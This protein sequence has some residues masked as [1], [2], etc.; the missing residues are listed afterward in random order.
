[1]TLPGVDRP[2]TLESLRLPARTRQHC[3]ATPPVD[4]LV[5]SYLSRLSADGTAARGVSAH[6]Y[7][8]RA[9][10]RIVTELSGESMTMAGLFQDDALLGRALIHDGSAQSSTLPTLT[11]AQR[12][13]A[14]R[15]FA[16]LMRPELLP[17]IK[18]D[19][20]TLSPWIAQRRSAMQRALSLSVAFGCSYLRSGRSA[21]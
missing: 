8:L 11:L 15:Y 10:L 20:S 19:P 4:A 21:L 7:Q 18:D 2:E 1:M 12:R 6:Q 16:T 9:T 13:S 14:I 5:Y 17:L 3:L